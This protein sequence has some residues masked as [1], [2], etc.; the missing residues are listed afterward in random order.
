MC[1]CT[2]YPPPD[3]FGAARHLLYN[4]SEAGAAAVAF[5]VPPSSREMQCLQRSGRQCASVLC[6]QTLWKAAILTEDKS[7]FPL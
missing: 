3:G 6:L 7:L 5:Y 4:Q 2:Q 1:T